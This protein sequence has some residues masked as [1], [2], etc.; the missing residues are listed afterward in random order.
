MMTV[1]PPSASSSPSPSSPSIKFHQ[2][3]TQ[4]FSIRTSI[5]TSSLYHRQPVN[6]KVRQSTIGGC[7]DTLW[8]PPS[9][10]P[11]TTPPTTLFQ[12]PTSPTL[13]NQIKT[14]RASGGATMM[15][16]LPLSP[17]SPLDR[18]RS[19]SPPSPLEFYAWTN[20]Y[21]TYLIQANH[22]P[23][24]NKLSI[25]KDCI[26]HLLNSVDH[27]TFTPIVTLKDQLSALDISYLNSA[28]SAALTGI[29]KSLLHILTTLQPALNTSAK[30]VDI[31]ETP[32]SYTQEQSCLVSSPDWDSSLDHLDHNTHW[33][34]TYFC[35]SDYTTLLIPINKTTSSRSPPSPSMYAVVTAKQE[36]TLVSNS[37]PKTKTRSN[38]TSTS[39]EST[40]YR[41]IV[42]HPKAATK[43]YLVSHSQLQD[44]LGKEEGKKSS[45]TQRQRSIRGY[46]NPITKIANPQQQDLIMAAISSVCPELDLGK[47]IKLSSTT[48]RACHL[49]KELLHL[50]EI[51]VPPAYKFGVL[52]IKDNQTNEEEWFSNTGVTDAFDRFLNLIGDRIQLLGYDGYAAGLDTKTGETGDTSVV[53][54]WKDYEIM[55]HVAALM[56]YH[57]ND[58]QQVQRKRYIGNDIVCLVFLE[59]NQVFDPNAIRS[60]FLHV[61]IV[62]RL[63]SVNGETRWRIEVVRK[64][65]VPEFGPSLPNPPLFYD[66]TTLRKFLTLKLISAEN[67][68]LKCDNFSVP[69]NRARAG[70]L[71]NIVE[72]GLDQEGTPSSASS[73]TIGKMTLDIKK[74]QSQSQ[75]RPKPSSANRLSRGSFRS[76]RSN[77]DNN[78]TT[79]T[80]SPEPPLPPL[81][82]PTRSTMLQD[83]KN[84][85]LRRAPTF[86]S[87]Q[88]RPSKVKEE[89]ATP[90][91]DDT[92]DDSNQE[93]PYYTSS[94]HPAPSISSSFHQQGGGIPNDSSI[95]QQSFLAA[96]AKFSTTSVLPNGPTPANS[97][98]PKIPPDGFY[99]ADN[100]MINVVGR[101]STSRSLLF[102]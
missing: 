93:Q 25:A 101:R 51:E 22:I 96:K 40:Q 24:I 73:T 78:G 23:S 81:P 29:L 35:N 7:L 5:S 2:R 62:V 85:A 26:C 99:K 67:A 42:R 10:D 21:L 66:D 41:V 55:F 94:M 30:L 60:K 9:T 19:S 64:N 59:G 87:F 45:K 4:S 89:P 20:E 27:E 50:D 46:Q 57:Q 61:Y 15:K 82:S 17:L 74:R 37:N 18:I 56:P 70:L 95:I 38:N 54:R 90:P 47:S 36:S 97:T 44:Y 31:T 33:F 84:F 12:M 49:E 16:K 43:R 83:L 80:P 34:Q 53:S 76:I 8:K 92:T 14:K 13:L 98:P 88:H 75:R 63:E 6:D 58:K 52:T 91:D 32:S 39:Y 65:N 86:S 69:N 68:A 11:L 100:L 71:K 77:P 3:L 28:P 1:A 72:K 102:D 79:S 48:T